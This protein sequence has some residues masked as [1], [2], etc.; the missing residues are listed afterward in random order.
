[1]R[2]VNRLV[3]P[4][5]GRVLIDGEDAAVLPVHELRRRIGY[6]IQNHGLFPHRTVAQNIATVPTLLGWD[7]RR[8]AARVEELLH[9]FQ[10][11]PATFAR[12]HP[13]ELSGGQQQRVGVARALAAEPKLLLMDEPFGALDPLVRAKAQDDLKAI[14]RQLS[15]TIIFVTHDMEEAIRLGDRIAVMDGGKLLQYAPPAEILVHPATPFVG[16]LIGVGDRPFRLLSL[17]TVAQEVEP[18]EAEGAADR[19]RRRPAR[20]SRRT[21]VV[22]SRR[23]AGRRTRRP[24]HRPRHARPADRA[25]GNADVRRRFARSAPIL[26]RALVVAA[27]VAFLVRPELFRPLLAP[28]CDPGQPVIYDRASLLSLTLSHLATVAISIGGATVVAV[29]LAILVTRPI[30]AEFLPLSRSIVNIGQ[31]FPPVAVLALAVPV[32]GFGEK[33]TLIALF[34]Y[35]LLPIFENAVTGLTSSAAGG[36][37][38]RQRHGHDRD[39]AAV[40]GRSAARASGDPR[41]RPAVGGHRARHRRDRLDRRRQGPRRS[42]HRRAAVEQPRVRRPRRRCRRRCSPSSFTKR[43]PASSAS[44]PAAPAASPRRKKPEAGLRRQPKN[45]A[46]VGAA[47]RSASASLSTQD[48]PAQAADVSS[49]PFG[50]ATLRAVR[51]SS[52]EVADFRVNSEA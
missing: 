52:A 16:A 12:R 31:T 49:P 25:R 8:I 29:G 35:G 33:P 23:R 22:A 36:R 4:T 42:H 51:P 48:G 10:L 17:E 5:S 26:L 44:S 43:S 40:E 21:A 9:L 1:M 13:H 19:G 18:G 46:V 24:R 39:A 45:A 14:Q 50:G 11:D 20:R 7:R 3:E 32:V 2:M 37:R 27:L 47:G 41:R 30:G 6:V 15:T 38:R 28:L 34:L